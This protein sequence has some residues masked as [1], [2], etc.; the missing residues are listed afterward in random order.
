MKYIEKWDIGVIGTFLIITRA[1]GKAKLRFASL[2]HPPS[3]SPRGCVF[4]QSRFIAKNFTSPPPQFVQVTVTN[5]SFVFVIREMRG[6]TLARPFF[7]S[8]LL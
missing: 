7:G 3:S 5:N 2:R 4:V 8:P 6:L 1:R